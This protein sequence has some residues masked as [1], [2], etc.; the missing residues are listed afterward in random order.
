MPKLTFFTE[1][2]QPWGNPD[3]SWAEPIRRL[4]AIV[5]SYSPYYDPALKFGPAFVYRDSYAIY[6]QP[7]SGTAD[8]ARNAAGI[9][10][11]PEWILRDTKGNPGYI[12]WGSKPYDQFAADIG[13]PE[14]C[15][16]VTGEV[17]ELLARGYAGVWLDD[18]NLDI[19]RVADA[20][21]NPANVLDPRTGQAMTPLAW[22]A[23]FAAYVQEL[24]AAVKAAGKQVLHN[25]IW[26]AGAGP[27]DPTVAAEIQAAD[28]IEL[29]NCFGDGGLTGGLG[30]WSLSA[31]LAFIQR[32]Y[33]AGRRPVAFEYQYQNA[34]YKVAC[35][36]LC[37]PMDPAHAL[38]GIGF[39]DLPPAGWDANLQ[40]LVLADLGTPAGPAIR[41]EG[42]WKRQY[43]AGAV[44]VIEPG[45]D[46]VHIGLDA[47]MTDA[48][49]GQQVTALDLHAG[50]GVV[51]LS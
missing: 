15:A 51:L 33:A 29:E 27:N 34:P 12:P 25:T 37:D 28:W 3:A 8:P 30:Q 26:F 31:K 49:T 7:G 20:N 24:G 9:V 18:V 47:P 23:Y 2:D 44:F 13:N 50:Q 35:M 6:T 42:I 10:A 38:G 22:K 32:V 11:R 48:A 17:L 46:S 16:F 39:A 19:S 43:S 21:G 41:I 5:A 1:T 14:Y 40:R 45:S 4:G 36:R